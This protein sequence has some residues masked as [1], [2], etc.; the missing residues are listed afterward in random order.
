MSTGSRRFRA[1]LDAQFPIVVAVL[2]VLVVGSGGLTYVTYASP[3]VTTEERPDSSWETTGAFEHSAT[4]TEDTAA[5]PAGTTLENRSVYFTEVTPWLNGTYAFEYEASDGGE[6]NMTVRVQL[7]LRG[8]EQTREN[9]TV[10]W[11]TSEPLETSRDG[12]LSPRGA[13]EVPFAINMNETANRTDRIEEQ[14]GDPPGQAEVEI[15]GVVE[16]V[17]RVNGREV[18]ASREH[19]LPIS[20]EE[21]VYRLDDPGELTD[22]SEATRTVTVERS[23][24]P[25]RSVGSPALLAMSLVALGGLVVARSRGELTLT[26]T[27]RELLAYEDDR[28]DLDEWISTMQLPKEAFDRPRAAATSLSAL[29]DFA[30]D[31][32][33]SV[34][35]DPNEEAYYVLH[36]GY[37]YTY[38][39]AAPGDER[40][41]TEG[42]DADGTEPGE[43]GAPS[44]PDDG[45]DPEVPPADE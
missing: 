8:V 39:P 26:P 18:E 43:G 10:V 38:R 37:L 1:L 14:L 36:D 23:P 16:M 45:P 25:L 19:A 15:R 21:G 41:E 12:A 44:E 30:I 4:V 20:L 6:L 7:I 29:V 42:V 28:T 3:P 11:E 33:N 9:T 31:T 17:G 24:G 40:P 27:E 34:I 5:Y 35:E 22:R 13:I 2:V 32:N